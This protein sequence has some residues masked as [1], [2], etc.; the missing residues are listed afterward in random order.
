MY[1]S[2]VAI[3]VTLVVGKETITGHFVMNVKKR[4]RDCMKKAAESLLLRLACKNRLL[5]CSALKVQKG[6]I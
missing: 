2:T 4:A 3:R 6:G 1:I 5:L